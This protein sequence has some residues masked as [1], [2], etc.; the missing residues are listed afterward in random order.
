VRQE[1]DHSD[2]LPFCVACVLAAI[3]LAPAA[4]WKVSA[5]FVLASLVGLVI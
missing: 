3:V 5:G 1:F 4:D 2:R